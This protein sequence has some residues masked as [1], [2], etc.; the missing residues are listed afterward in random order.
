MLTVHDI[1]LRLE[2]SFNQLGENGLFLHS[3]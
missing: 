1:L 2:F 3:R